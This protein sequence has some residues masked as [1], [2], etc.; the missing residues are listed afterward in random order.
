[1]NILLYFFLCAPTGLPIPVNLDVCLAAVA[2]VQCPPHWHCVAD[3]SLGAPV[4]PLFV[5]LVF[6]RLWFWFCLCTRRILVIIAIRIALVCF[7]IG[8]GG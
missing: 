7:F 5:V 4:G 2:R 6:I 3:W 8:V 1:M